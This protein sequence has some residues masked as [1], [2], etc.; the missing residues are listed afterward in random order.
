MTTSTKKTAAV[1]GATSGLGETAALA[2]ARA[3][4]RVLV[5]GRDA[6]RGAAVVA[7]AKAA[8][9]DAEFLAADLFSLADV[10]RLATEIRKRAPAL[11]LL[12]NNAGGSFGPKR[13]TGDGLER[14]FAL[15]VAAPFVLT[16][17]LVGQLA[18]AKGRVVNIVTGV[19]KGAKTT[20][21]QLTGKKSDGGMQSYIRNKLALLTFTNEAQRR[22][23]A[24]GITFV[25][26]HP[27][28]IP[29]TRFGGEMPA[30]MRSVGP[31]IARLFGLASTFEQAAERYFQ[32][33]TGPV[34]PGGFYA[35][36][37]LKAAPVQTQD[38]AFA[39]TLWQHLEELTSGRA[40]LS[41][42]A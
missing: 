25:S 17:G 8:G 38:A 36:G 31:F 28:V 23:G 16:E 26:L 20:L 13:L 10:R 19:P 41:A 27:G 29:N 32:A 34:D 37:V 35:E 21:D 22:H 7:Q 18:A 3:G 15:N 1:T 6:E 24:R 42:A 9:G 4:W 39:A 40:P 33:G 5:I 11:D 12:I 30:F 14:T 2:L